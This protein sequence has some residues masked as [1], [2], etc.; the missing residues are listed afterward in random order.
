M[1]EPRAFEV[2]RFEWCAA[3]GGARLVTL[4]GRWTTGEEPPGW[5]ALV[6]ERNGTLLAVVPLPSAGGGGAP[7]VAALSLPAERVEDA[8]V[9]FRVKGE[10]LA[11][12]R[13]GRPAAAAGDTHAPGADASP[14]RRDAG[15]GGGE[16]TS[17]N[18]GEG[19]A[20]DAGEDGE[21]DAPKRD[22]KRR[23]RDLEHDLERERTA[24]AALE[25]ALEAASETA[26]ALTRTRG[27]KE[28]LETRLE[29][30]EAE[31]DRL[32]EELSAASRSAHEW[33]AAARAR[34]EELNAARG[35]VE[36]TLRQLEA[37]VRE[38]DEVRE[39]LASERE[40]RTGAEQNAR[41]ARKERDAAVERGRAQL[42]GM[43][44]AAAARDLERELAA[45]REAV[46][47]ERMTREAAE[48]ALAQ[49]RTRAQSLAERSERVRAEGNKQLAALGEV[50]AELERLAATARELAARN[51]EA[52]GE[53]H[54]GQAPDRELVEGALRE[55]RRGRQEAAE[56]EQRVAELSSALIEGTS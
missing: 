29:L 8:G 35:E 41:T 49:E 1:H 2:E 18:G 48:A 53:E 47:D 6:A 34:E 19:E 56:L 27:A 31:R 26:E 21:G 44:E 20:H 25:E 30:I 13:L 11:A 39:E 45:A 37:S 7:L 32:A 12:V 16:A 22:K 40:A 10:K 24:R 15:A 9:S 5:T 3:G 36:G 42:A 33:A 4:A 52:S 54:I 46:G 17:P 14:G 23:L 50:E 38:A 51:G 28:D 43:V 55:V